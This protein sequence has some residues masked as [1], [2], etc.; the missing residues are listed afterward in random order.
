MLLLRLL[1]LFAVAVL[2]PA[3]T[4]DI[5]DFKATLETAKQKTEE[6]IRG[7]EQKWHVKDYPNFLKS[8]AMSVTSWEVLKVS[9]LT[10]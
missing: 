8:V 10:S 3:S 7:I 2:L 4:K 9:Q 6:I 1:C 5:N